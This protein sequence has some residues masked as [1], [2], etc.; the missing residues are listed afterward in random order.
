M[1]TA[2]SFHFT[3]AMLRTAFNRARISKVELK[4]STVSRPANCLRI[5]LPVFSTDYPTNL[6]ENSCRF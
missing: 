3:F 4:E 2:V 5:A 6:I 1:I